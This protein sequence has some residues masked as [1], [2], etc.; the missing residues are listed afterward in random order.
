MTTITIDYVAIIKV[1]HYK[2]TSNGLAKYTGV[3][4]EMNLLVANESS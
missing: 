1:S 2:V 4:Q 3:L